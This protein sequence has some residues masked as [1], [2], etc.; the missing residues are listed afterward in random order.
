M[1]N[2]IADRAEYRRPKITACGRN[3][4]W[5]H[6]A[7]HHLAVWHD[8]HSGCSAFWHRSNRAATNCCIYLYIYLYIYIYL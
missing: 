4:A 3:A 8:W 1:A 6:T 2:L 7:N 5:S